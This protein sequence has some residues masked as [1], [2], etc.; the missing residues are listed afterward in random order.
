MS[1]HLEPIV[2]PVVY[3]NA[4]ISRNRA[5]SLRPLSLR[6]LLAF[7]KRCA[8]PR[9]LAARS[10]ALPQRTSSTSLELGRAPLK[11][12]PDA[13]SIVGAIVNATPYSL[14]PL[15]SLRVERIRFGEYAQLLLQ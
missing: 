13:L 11:E 9:V 5:V 15:E 14:N 6:R 1:L 2:H 10:I 12:R 4:V 3:P 7:G 8:R